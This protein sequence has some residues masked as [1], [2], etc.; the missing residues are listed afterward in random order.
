MNC[1]SSCV[2]P[3]TPS[4][5]PQ[6]SCK[7]FQ[8]F[9]LGRTVTVICEEDDGYGVKSRASIPCCEEESREEKMVFRVKLSEYIGVHTHT[10]EIAYVKSN[11]NYLGT[12]KMYN[13]LFLCCF[14]TI[15][16]LPNCISL[17]SIIPQQKYSLSSAHDPF[18][19][20]AAFDLFGTGL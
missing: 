17:F 12:F 9:D 18:P 10:H 15:E 20:P 14:H 5:F 16:F 13:F 2:L 8:T 6:A 19:P 3:R 1:C 7:S 11:W 4:A